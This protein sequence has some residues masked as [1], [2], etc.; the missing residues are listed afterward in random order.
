MIN[1]FE[2]YWCR[3]S[4]GNFFCWQSVEWDVAISWQ[5]WG[6]CGCYGVYMAVSGLHPAFF[7]TKITLC[8]SYERALREGVTVSLAPDLPL[9]LILTLPRK[10]PKHDPHSFCWERWYRRRNSCQGKGQQICLRAL[11]MMSNISSSVFG[12]YI[13]KNCRA[14]TWPHSEREFNL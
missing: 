3:K 7:F 10:N 8:G 4:G 13:S 1:N 6:L 5:L 11:T 9:T 14:L 2:S 12:L